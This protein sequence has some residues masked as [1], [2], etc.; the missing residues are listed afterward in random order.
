M[1]VRD[2]IFVSGK[3]VPSAGSDVI[4]VISTISVETIATIPA[5]TAEDVD[6]AA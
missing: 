2:Q 6:L 5:G 3:W 1:I 4:P